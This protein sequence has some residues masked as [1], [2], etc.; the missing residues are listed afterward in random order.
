VAGPYET[1]PS[2]AVTNRFANPVTGAILRTRA[3]WAF[4]RLVA[5]EYVGR[6]SGATHRL[7]AQAA[8]EADPD[9]PLV[10][11]V[12]KP[13][14]KTW[15]RNFRGEAQPVTV[16]FRGRRIAATATVL[17]P[18]ERGPAIDAYQQ[19]FGAKAATSDEPVI[20]IVPTQR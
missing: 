2:F 6:R 16:W 12:G 1:T 17:A 7:V 9:G 20:R 18:D 15:W 8:L 11:V 4:G 19:V 10:V 3:G 5:L 13:G 14:A